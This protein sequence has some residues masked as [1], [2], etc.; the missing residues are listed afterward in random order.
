MRTDIILSS[1]SP[2]LTKFG[3]D[4]Q[5]LHQMSLLTFA[6]RLSDMKCK[7]SCP[8][9]S[10]HRPTHSY[11]GHIIALAHMAFELNQSVPLCYYSTCNCLHYTEWQPGGACALV[12]LAVYNT[13]VTKYNKHKS[14]NALY[15]NE[16]KK[17]IINYYEITKN[18]I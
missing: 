4:V 6:T 11:L 16:A 15:K 8:L 14:S 13:M 18:I 12:V 5:H 17:P 2:I 1:K 3:T 9:I 10:R 7:H